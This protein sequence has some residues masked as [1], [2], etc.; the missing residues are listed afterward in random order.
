MYRMGNYMTFQCAALLLVFS[1]D[2]VSHSIFSNILNVNFFSLSLIQLHIT[3]P[4]HV[5]K[6]LFAEFSNNLTPLL[7]YNKIKQRKPLIIFGCKI[8]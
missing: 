6:I 2:L 4:F 8:Y 3:E 1:I 5:L 7:P